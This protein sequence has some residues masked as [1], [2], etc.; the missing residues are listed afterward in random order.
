M[1]TEEA[2]W[3][4]D[5]RTE[6]RGQGNARHLLLFVALL[7]PVIASTTQTHAFTNTSKNKC[8]C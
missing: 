1:D 3:T 2:E 6:K 4:A 8:A 7:D 5:E